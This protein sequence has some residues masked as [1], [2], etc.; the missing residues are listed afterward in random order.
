L[1]VGAF[2]VGG[3]MLFLWLGSLT[4]SPS[5]GRSLDELLCLAGLCFVLRTPVL[6]A[7]VLAEE[8]RNQTLGLLF[9][10]GLGPGEVF[11]SKFLSAALVAFN[12]LLAMFPTL[13]LPFLI[14]GVSF[15]LFLATVCALPCLM[16]FALAVSLLASVLSQDDGAAVVLAVVMGA[17]LCVL[18]PAIYLAQTA[19]SVGA[20]PSAWWLLLS[21]AYGPALIWTGF[22]SGFSPAAAS[23]FWKNLAMTLGWSALFLGA[24]SVALRWLWRE[25][26]ETRS[27]A[28]WALWWH[29]FFHGQPQHRKRLARTWLEV[30]PF[31]WLAA[32]DRQPARLAWIVVGGVVGL[33]LLCWAAWPAQWPSALNLFLTAII[34]NLSLGWIVRYTAAKGIGEP[35]RDRVYEVLLTTPLQPKDIVWGEMEAIRWHFLPVA[36]TVFGLELLMMLGGLGVRRWDGGALGVYFMLWFFILFWAWDQ[37]RRWQRVLPVMWT[38]LNSARPAHATWRTSGFGSWSWL[39]IL[40]NLANLSRGF[41]RF[42]AFP[43]GSTVEVV[44][45]GMGSLVFLAWLVSKVPTNAWTA[46]EELRN[47]IRNNADLQE[48]RLVQE[49]RE[50]VREPLPDP[51]DPRFKKWNVQERFPWGWELTQQQL[52]ERLARSKRIA[53]AEARRLRDKYDGPG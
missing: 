46:D 5:L 42:Y 19:F 33:W 34:L 8:R 25:R 6:T 50:I 4:G 9:L 12:D 21:P 29:E 43:T 7:G 32:R 14:G 41:S 51:N 2:S 27:S 37:G 16:L 28:G 10:S 20:K 45:V 1:R 22:S 18:T 24:A 53:E 47:E 40:F 49:F 36:R 13:A 17:A 26:E 39:W 15:E 52:H 30:N 44:M 48:H 38:S 35:R 31:V 11:A 23:A 3:A